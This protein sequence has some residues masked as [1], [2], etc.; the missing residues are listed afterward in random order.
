MKRVR[1]FAAAFLTA[2]SVMMACGAAVSADTYFNIVMSRLTS[3]SVTLTWDEQEYANAYRLYMYDWENDE[4]HRMKTV[5]D[6]SCTFTGLKPSA[7]YKLKIQAIHRYPDGTYSEL[8][9]S[10]AVTLTTKAAKSTAKKMPSFPKPMDYGFIFTDIDDALY[11]GYTF[12]VSGEDSAEAM[13]KYRKAFTQKG[14]TVSQRELIEEY[15]DNI[16]T[17]YTVYYNGKAVGKTVEIVGYSEGVY[18]LM[19]GFSAV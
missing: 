10:G 6:E 14:F 2:V 7:R 17:Y 5:T 18:L 3:S 19:V 4:W 15:E 13:N 12:A 16:M 1:N 11:G 9:T 8:D